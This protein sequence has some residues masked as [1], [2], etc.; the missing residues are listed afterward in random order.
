MRTQLP[1][2]TIIGNWP[3]KL[4]TVYSPINMLIYK[5]VHIRYHS[6]FR[7]NMKNH[8]RTDRPT[9]VSCAPM[10]WHK[11]V[12][13]SLRSPIILCWHYSTIFYVRSNRSLLKNVW[14]YKAIRRN[15]YSMTDK[16]IQWMTKR[17]RT[18]RHTKADKISDYITK[19]FYNKII[20]ACFAVA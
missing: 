2:T 14:K 6:I 12:F 8:A 17:Q 13:I 4:I 1:S 16:P 18:K 20:S 7:Y 11:L 5:I 19:I 10:V 15:R 9:H 3:L